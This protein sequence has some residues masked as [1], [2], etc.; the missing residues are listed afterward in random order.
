MPETKSS[1]FGSSSEDLEFI[2]LVAPLGK[3]ALAFLTDAFVI[4]LLLF[5]VYKNLIIPHSFPGGMSAY[6]LEAI[7]LFQQLTNQTSDPDY[8][9]IPEFKISENMQN[10]S[11]F[12]ASMLFVGFAFYFS[13]MELFLDRSSLGKKIFKLRSVRRYDLGVPP[14]ITVIAR[15]IVKSFTMISGFYILLNI[16]PMFFSK[17]RQSG[18]DWIFRTIVIQEDMDSEDKS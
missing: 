14:A 10:A 9:G 18:H 11:K 2:H 15:S 13:A 5:L 16:L 3:R 6:E 12:F 7:D 8:S 4:F 17:F 1:E